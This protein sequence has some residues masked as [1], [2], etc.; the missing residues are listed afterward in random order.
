M[1][2][3]K[4]LPN[5]SYHDV[6]V[7]VDGI[8]Y[9][10][11]DDYGIELTCNRVAGWALWRKTGDTLDLRNWIKIGSEHDCNDFCVAVGRVAICGVIPK[12]STVRQVGW[13]GV[14]TNN[15]QQKR[16]KR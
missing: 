4:K 8:K 9:V 3:R 15:A 16:G 5:Y 13:D 11:K 10:L 12:A 6:V 7:Y 1:S 2:K 14:V